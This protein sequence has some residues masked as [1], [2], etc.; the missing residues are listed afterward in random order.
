MQ[1]SK[2]ERRVLHLLAWGKKYPEILYLIN[3]DRR[4]NPVKGVF[5]GREMS[6]STLHTICCRIRKKTGIKSTKDAV[7]CRN[8][9]KAN[10]VGSPLQKEHGPTA[11]QTEILLR[12]AAGERYPEICEGMMLSPQAAMNLASEARKRVKIADNLPSSVKAFFTQKAQ[13]PP[14]QGFLDGDPCF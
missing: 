6:L 8:W 12:L 10:P 4:K 14:I 11:R 7:E 13:P 2:T 9:E 3:E 5:S 1:L